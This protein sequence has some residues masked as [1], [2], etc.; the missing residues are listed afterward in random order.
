MGPLILPNVEEAAGILQRATRCRQSTGPSAAPT[1]TLVTVCQLA[2]TR[3]DPSTASHTLLLAETYVAP[4]I[5][6][7]QAKRTLPVIFHVWRRG[8]FGAVLPAPVGTSKQRGRKRITPDKPCGQ[9]GTTGGAP[10]TDPQYHP[11]RGRGSPAVHMEGSSSL[12]WQTGT[13]RV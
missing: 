2:R 7:L 6:I 8:Q 12:S 3:R 4:I 10:D 11:T 5:A 13:G 1:C 9:G